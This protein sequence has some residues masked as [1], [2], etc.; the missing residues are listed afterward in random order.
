MIEID[1]RSISEWTRLGM[2]KAFGPIL[3]SVA[4]DHPELVAMAADVADSANL[5]SFSKTHSS[6]FFNIGIAEQNMTAIA[7]G[8]AKEGHNVFICSFAP[9]VSMRNYEAVRTLV[10]YMGLNV[11]IVA[12]ASGLSLGVQGSTHY[13]LEDISLMRTIPGMLVLSPADVIE[14][15]KC[16]EFLANYYGPAYLRL[17]GIDGTPTVFNSEYVFDEGSLELIREGEDLVIFSTGSVTSECIRAT[18]ALKKDGIKC[19]LYSLCRLKPI[20]EEKITSILNQYKTVITAEE[21]FKIGGLGDIVSDIVARRGLQCKVMK[22]GVD[23]SFPHPGD[24]AYVLAASNLTA[25]K[26][27]DI[28]VSKV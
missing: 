17:T 23:D 15:A 25:A 19:A 16:I 3:E 1:K 6:Q 14:E 12:L 26:I 2:R 21:H 4:D 9:F 20:D 10:G 5:T 28:I 8:M 22:I 7:C 18:R 11:K 24:Y 27:R 13:C